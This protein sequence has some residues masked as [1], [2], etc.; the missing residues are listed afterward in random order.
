MSSN[1]ETRLPG[2]SDDRVIEVD[3][4]HVIIAFSTLIISGVAVSTSVILLRDHI[5]ARR[6]TIFITSLKELL[7]SINLRKEHPGES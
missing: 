2:E 5:K 7:S 1:P 4:K 3:L 6:Q